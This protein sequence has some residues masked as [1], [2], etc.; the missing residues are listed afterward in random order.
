MCAK[1]LWKNNERVHN[2]CCYTGKYRGTADN[3]CN[4]RYKMPK[5]IPMV[6]HNGSNFDYHFI[7]TKLAEEFGGQLKCLGENT[8]KYKPFQ[9]Q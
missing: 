4:L 1:R 8:E 9:C 5:E 7:I 2:H 6:F 3:I